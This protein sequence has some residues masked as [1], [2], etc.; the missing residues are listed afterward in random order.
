MLHRLRPRTPPLGLVPLRW[1]ASNHS[2]EHAG[3]PQWAASSTVSPSV[4]RSKK[5]TALARAQCRRDVSEILVQLDEPP[6]RRGASNVR[7]GHAR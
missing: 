2:A 7:V 4:V 1:D 6:R 5:T 3:R